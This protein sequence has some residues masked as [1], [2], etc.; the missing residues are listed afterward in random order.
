MQ[1]TRLRGA[2]HE[3]IGEIATLAEG[4]AAVALSRG[5]AAKR[6]R[7]RHANEDAAGFAHGPSGS[8]AA[9]ADG[10][11]GREAAELAVAWACDE[12]APRWTGSGESDL[13]PRFASEART[14]AA[15][16]HAHILRASLGVGGAACR[17]TLSLAL[18]RPGE[19][20]F[21]HW[22]LGDSHVFE[23]APG[24]VREPCPQPSGDLAFLGDA[25]LP[26]E[27]LALRVRVGLGALPDVTCLVL[28]TDGLSERGIGV[29]SPAAV[30]AE[31]VAQ[32]SGRPADLRPLAV[33]RA[34]AERALAAQ[35]AHRSGDN[36]ATA[37]LWPAGSAR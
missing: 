30:V 20:W 9:V 10:H 11:G 27:A 31:L 16:M 23:A 29:A 7:Y 18:V 37:V 22:S 33:A 28:A 13:R 12:L 6:Y 14:A 24:G 3:T 25:T 34:L 36:V 4:A 17:T 15:A 32:A 21:G 35:R 26:S 8:L 5:G 19:G 1:P 2:D